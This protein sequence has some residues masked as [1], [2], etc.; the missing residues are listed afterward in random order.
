MKHADEVWQ[1][2]LRVRHLL[3]QTRPGGKNSFIVVTHRSAEAREE[4]VT[5]TKQHPA[6]LKKSRAGE[7]L[8]PPG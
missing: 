7:K 5:F 1:D 6:R 8:Y 2:G 4:V 3:H